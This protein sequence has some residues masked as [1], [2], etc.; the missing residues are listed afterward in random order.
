M[1]RAYMLT[2]V[3]L[4]LHEQDPSTGR[5]QF[6]KQASTT[7]PALDALIQPEGV[8]SA[9]EL[10]RAWFP[11]VDA[12]VFISHAGADEQLALKLA[13]FLRETFGLS[14]FV[15]SQVWG[16]VDHLL[17]RIDNEYCKTPDGKYYD[18]HK[19]NRST[20]H[21]HVILASALTQ[22]LDRTEC[23]FFLATPSSMTSAD[24]VNSPDKTLSPWVHHELAMSAAIQKPLDRQTVTQKLA[25]A[26]TDSIRAGIL[27]VAFDLP[28]LPALGLDALTTW[29]TEWQQMPSRRATDALDLL[30]AST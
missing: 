1:H 6:E 20:A 9:G 19:R 5:R 11:K 4:L 24:V 15:D 12:S 8:L 23:L 22:M 16:Y 29:A 27:Q 14:S 13:S 10:S 30:Y 26:R 28:D 3:E 18:Y 17:K 7:R 25:K 21:V 2:D